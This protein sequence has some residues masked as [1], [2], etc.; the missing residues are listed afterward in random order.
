MGAM[1]G[2]MIPGFLLDWAVVAVSLFNTILL[3][4]LGLTVLLNADRRTWGIWMAG[5]GLL[6]GGAFFVSHTAILGTGLDVVSP[7]MDLWWQAGWVPVLASPI[8]WYVVMLWYSGFWDSQQAPIYL[9]H[10]LWLATMA[11][12]A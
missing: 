10:R 12:L 1:G 7:N 11:A 4:W 9:R 8:A 6:A 5:G 2:A 3:L